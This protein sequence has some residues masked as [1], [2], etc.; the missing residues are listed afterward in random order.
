[1]TPV[2]VATSRS[3]VSNLVTGCPNCNSDAYDTWSATIG[4]DR[5]HSTQCRCH[6]CGLVFSNPQCDPA[7]INRYY[8]R[9]YYEDHW[10]Q[11]IDDDETAVAEVAARLMPEVAR[12]KSLVQKGSLLEVGSGTGG[13]LRLMRDAGFDTHGVEL[14]QTGVDYSRRV[15]SLSNI[16]QG[17]LED[18]CYRAESFDLIYVWHVIEHVIDLNGF[19]RELHRVMRPDSVLWLGTENYRNSSYRLARLASL[20]KGLPPPFATSSEHTFAF[21]GQT[22]S[23]VLERRGFKILFCETYQPSWREKLQTMQFRSALGKGYFM[24]QHLANYVCRT[25]PLIRLAARRRN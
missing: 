4:D 7:T 9:H 15:H 22:L 5:L 25:G 20:L 3:M 24:S 11:L 6:E 17:T 18:A 10:P 21:T 19:V 12:I 14:S 8:T 1:M 13:F 16:R 2:E 23:D